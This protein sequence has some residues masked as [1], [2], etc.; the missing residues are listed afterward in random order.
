M[1]VQDVVTRVRRT[2]GD[3]AAVDDIALDDDVNDTR[4]VKSISSLFR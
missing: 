2:F 3:D 1:I 4:L